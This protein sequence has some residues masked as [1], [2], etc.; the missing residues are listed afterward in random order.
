M[1]AKTKTWIAQVE[2]GNLKTNMAIVLDHIMKRNNNGLDSDIYN[3]RN[4]LKLPHQTLT[5]TMSL[6]ADEG[7]IVEIG[8]M[9]IEGS[10]Y[11][12]WAY[13]TDETKRKIIS[14]NRLVDKFN[15]WV[16]RGVE[17]YAYLMSDNVK[18]ELQEINDF[19]EALR[20]IA[21][22]ID[23]SANKFINN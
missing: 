21:S 15:Q 8:Q 16:K 18:N 19:N 1:K 14:H 17:E 11:T 10:T 12:R 20:K 13:V 7:L 23:K 3:M 5:G 2:S 22:D 4:Q 6:L 9:Q